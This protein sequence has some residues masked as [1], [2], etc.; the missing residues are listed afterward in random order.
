MITQKVNSLSIKNYIQKTEE[1]ECIVCSQAYDMKLKMPM[2]ICSSQHNLCQACVKLCYEKH[3]D[4]F[5]CP[6]C[7]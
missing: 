4:H 6:I 1:V 3:G 7:N 5:K 2:M